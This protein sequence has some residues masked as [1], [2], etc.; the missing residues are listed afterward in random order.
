M[1]IL[2]TIR[3]ICTVAFE[4]LRGKP[5]VSSLQERGAEERRREQEGKGGKV[6]SNVFRLWAKKTKR[7]EM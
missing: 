6:T 5:R 1:F 2:Q 7:E 3:V 4:K